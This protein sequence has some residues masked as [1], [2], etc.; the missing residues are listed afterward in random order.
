MQK[1]SDLLY[2]IVLRVLASFYFTPESSLVVMPFKTKILL[3]YFIEICKYRLHIY[4]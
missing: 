3:P 1:G 2:S 4:L